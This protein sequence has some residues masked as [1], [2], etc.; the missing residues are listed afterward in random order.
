VVDEIYQRGLGPE[1]LA[2]AV[3]KKDAAF[4]RELDG[5]IDSAAF[6][7]IG[8]GDGYGKGSRGD[9]MNARGCRWRPAEKGAGSRLHGIS[10]IHQKLALKKDGF[11]G[12]VVFRNCRNLIRTLPAMVYSRVHPEDIDDGCEQHAVDALRY[13]LTRKRVWCGEVPVYGI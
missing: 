9:Q 10:V 6:A 4:E 2:D 12:L 5:T 13:G 7:E 1:D 8:L 3:L 11:G